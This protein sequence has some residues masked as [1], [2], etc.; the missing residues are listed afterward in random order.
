MQDASSF[1][2]AWGA[3]TICML[4]A[5]VL[6]GCISAQAC[7]YFSKFKKDRPIL[8]CVIALIWLGSALHFACEFRILHS[9][10][11][12][13]YPKAP[14]EVTIP[15]EFSIAIIL[16]VVVHCCAQGVYIYRMHRFGHRVWILVLCCVLVVLEL[17]FGLVI[18]AR[19]AHNASGAQVNAVSLQTSW[20]ITAVFA[21]SAALDASITI[22][23]CV[24]LRQGR[25]DGIKRT[26]YIVDRII[27]WT[28]QS[29]VLTSAVAITIVAV[30]NTQHTRELFQ[31]GR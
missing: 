6:N 27:Q 13:G 16:Q 15:F 21:T 9:V 29:A 26:R 2:E 4:L 5:A 30:W 31:P 14:L 20:V 3:I 12:T 7:T 24:Q 17:A 10:L 11:I 1:A 18:A 28:V 19:M 23:I 22:S 8:R 25:E